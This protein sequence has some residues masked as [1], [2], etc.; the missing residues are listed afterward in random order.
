MRCVVQI[1]YLLCVFTTLTIGDILA[2]EMPKE[3][4]TKSYPPYA[5]QSYPTTVYWGDTHLH[6][7]LSADAY[8]LGNEFLGPDEAY[9]FA[10]GEEVRTWSGLNARRSRPLD[11]LVIADH[12]A[13]M[14]FMGAVIDKQDSSLL[15]TNA[16]KRWK[17]I[18]LGFATTNPSNKR[19]DELFLLRKDMMFLGKNQADLTEVSRPIWENAMSLADKHNTPGTFTAFIGYEWTAL[20]NLH[21]VVVFKDGANK[22]G[23]IL[24][25]S[26]YDSSN[27][28]V[29]WRFMQ[30]YEVNTGGEVLAIPHNAN[31]TNG[32]MFA[33]EDADGNPISSTYAK[34]RS[35]WEPLLEVTQIKGDSESHPF[36]SP[37]DEF[38]D[39]E[40]ME[41]GSLSQLITEQRKKGY[42]EYQNWYD[43]DKRRQKPSDWIRHEYARSALK[44]GLDQQGKVGV[45]PFK[46]GM[47]GST[48]SHTSLAVAEEDNFWGSMSLSA[49]SENRILR[50]WHGGSLDSML[51]KYFGAAWNQNASGYAAV[52]AEEN[53]RESLFAAMKRKE[54]YASTG[55]RMSVRFFGGWDFKFDDALKPNLA[56]IGYAKGVPMGGDLTRAPVDKSPRFLI[57]AIRDPRGANL[58]RVQVIKGWRDAKGELFEKIYN[59]ALSDN[60]KS[61]WLG[62]VKTVGSTVDITNASYTNSIGDPEL[63]VVWQDPDF[64]K[65]ELAFYY[66][67]VLEIPTPRWPAYDAKFFG[68]KDIPE[69]VPMVTQERAYTSPIWY[70]PTE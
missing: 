30:D 13:A 36:L 22:V 68:I 10:K 11:F 8:Q 20:F 39:F 14:G 62:N 17:K 44:L 53:T 47:I 38:S 16:G 40:T 34:N 61:N 2:V 1:T 70:S 58:D 63:A 60:R 29:L 67:R 43:E 27:P 42:S 41:A 45:N 48:D 31:R 66:V 23:S 5:N 6:T 15:N 57:R 28:E 64:N 54:V 32:V 24:P 12:A 21:R 33:L 37:D 18:A 9:R 52:W 69:E 19:A 59:V 51:G 55:P 25:L 56:Q 26:S 3:G 65:D 46:F 35:R 7:N 4:R 50:A 49:P